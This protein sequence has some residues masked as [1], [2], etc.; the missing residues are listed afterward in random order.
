MLTTRQRPTGR[1]GFLGQYVAFVWDD[2]TDA[3]SYVFQVG[4]AT[5]QSDVHNADVGNVLSHAVWLD[6]GTYYS[7]VVPYNGA[8]PMTALAEQT[9]TV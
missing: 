6:P 9:V 1:P 3:T 7:R 4:T 2:V 8:S 5:G